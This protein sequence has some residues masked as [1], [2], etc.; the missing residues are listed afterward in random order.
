[1]NKPVFD[2]IVDIC[3]THAQRLRWAMEQLAQKKPL[4][5]QAL[6]KLTDI[7]LAVCD[8]F[9]V[10]FSKLQDAMGAKL[11]P[12]VIELTH[13]EGELAT[14][15]DKL[16]RLEKI[17]ALTSVD[18]WLKLREMRNQFAHDYPNDPEIQASLLNKAFDMAAQLL[19]ILDQVVVFSK[20]YN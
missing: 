4:T 2:G 15:I 20:K 1:M 18:Q 6:Q 11:L 8:Q 12:A 13:E 16:N 14:F 7:E 10:R 5:A 17:G 19:T 3:Q 9:I